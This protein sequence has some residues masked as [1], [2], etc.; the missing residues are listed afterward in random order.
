MDMFSRYEDEFEDLRQS[1]HDKLR[2]VKTTQAEQKTD[3]IK[4][5]EQDIYDA[6][7]LVQTMEIGAMSS[8]HN[9]KVEKLAIETTGWKTL[10]KTAKYELDREALLGNNNDFNSGLDSYSDDKQKVLDATDNFNSGSGY[11]SDG[12]RLA[13]E[14]RDSGTK[15]IEELER[16][17]E[18]VK[19]SRLSLAGI[20]EE[21]TQAGR[22]MR[23]ISLKLITNKIILA[24]LAVVLII[25]ILIILYFGFIRKYFK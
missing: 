8:D 19:K 13:H 3:L 21:L 6:E 4:S 22:T 25:F 12:L 2:R 14:I 1:F 5:A 17:R 24:L 7:E 9:D 23:K 15:T 11:I 20:N 10:L 16:Q 18:Q